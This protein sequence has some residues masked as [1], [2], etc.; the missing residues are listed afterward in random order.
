MVI[1]NLTAIAAQGSW[2][3]VVVQADNYGAETS[4]EI[5]EDSTL[6]ATSP[7]YLNNSYNETLVYLSPGGYNFVVYDEF[8]DGICCDWGTG[9]FGLVN[10]CGLDTF[11]YDFG[12]PTA[13]VY[14]DLLA[15][16]PPV[17]GCMDIEALNFNPWANAPAPCTFLPAACDSG[18]TNIIVLTTP[19]SYPSET[20]WELTANGEIIS[21]GGNFSSTG[22]A[23]PSYVCVNEGDTLVATIY[24]SFGDGL[25]GSCWGGVDGYFNVTTLCGDSIFTAGGETQFDTIVS[26]L[27]VVPACVPFI[28]EGCTDSGYV[29][30]NPTAVID[31]NSCETL[32]EL[33]CI[34]PTMFNYD[35]LANTMDVYPFCEYTLTTTD[36]GADGWFGSWMGLTQGDNI[37]GPYQMGPDD[38]YEEEFTL[39]LTSNEEVKVYFFT[40]GNSETT[41]A[42]CGFRLEGPNGILL[43]SGTNPWTDPLKKFPY[44]YI[45][46]P[47]CSNYCVEV[48]AACTDPEAQNFTLGANTEDGSCYYSAGCTQAGYLEYYSQEYEADFD[49]GSCNELAVFGCTDELS[50]NYNF[51]AN[52]DIGNCI[53]VI[54]DCMDL[55]AANYN[56]L[57]NTP[58]ND[59]CLYDAGCIGEPGAPYWLNDSC[60]AWVITIDPYCCET[61]WDNACIN[62]YE[63]CSDGWPT[64]IVAVDNEIRIY[65]NP[66]TDRLNVVTTLQVSTELYN[67]S[68]QLIRTAPG[69]IEMSDL[70]SGMYQA[71]IRYN[72]RLITKKIVKQ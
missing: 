54:V 31:N 28:P 52:V 16:P 6:V 18:Q 12:G 32:I 23:V 42:Q 27:Y 47:T 50:L 65:P 37:Y 2:V 57:A 45:A 66:V 49:D 17:F 10:S 5:Y 14:F 22:V 38:G 62:L 4:W 30:Y 69:T 9:Y 68:G 29:E 36:G 25:C 61:S 1:V 44:K 41:A 8:G 56:E 55:D 11:V 34:D 70:P 35:S 60:Y 64:D 48:L 7:V 21:S 33:G 71:V 15:C 13:T 46:T 72:N 24:D 59:S 3:S 26:G 67:S 63:Y 58:D 39:D 19:D 40:S 20:S 43:E 51:E 53:E